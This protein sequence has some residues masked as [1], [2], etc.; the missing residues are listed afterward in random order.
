MREILIKEKLLFI[1]L[2]SWIWY[3]SHFISLPCNEPGYPV[4]L[5]ANF[6][7]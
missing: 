6:H 4:Q 2:E 1:C 3:W 7:T 5:S